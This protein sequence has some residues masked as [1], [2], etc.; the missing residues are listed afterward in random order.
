[1]LVGSRVR[2]STIPKFWPPLINKR[3]SL[4]LFYDHLRSPILVLTRPP[5]PSPFAELWPPIHTMCDFS[6][7]H[8]AQWRTEDRYVSPFPCECAPSIHFYRVLHL[9][10]DYNVSPFAGD[11]SDIQMD[12]RTEAGGRALHGEDASGNK[13]GY[14]PHSIP[15]HRQR[16][17]RFCMVIGAIVVVC[18]VVGSVVGGTVGTKSTNNNLAVSSPGPHTTSLYPSSTRYRTISTSSSRHTPTTTSTPYHTSGASSQL[19]TP[20][21]DPK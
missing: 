2:K 20:T 16:K 12:A 5:H 14:S 4:L 13:K 7:W 21:T 1:M 11:N 3:D 10:G 19:P 6:T 15:W 17:W 8:R 9:Q 18:V